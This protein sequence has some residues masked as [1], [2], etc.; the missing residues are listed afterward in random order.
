MKRLSNE[1]LGDLKD[2]VI[3]SSY[4]RDQLQPGIVHLGLGAF[5]RAHQAVFTERAIARGDLRWGIVGV[6]LRSPDTADALGPQDGL[7]TVCVRDSGK[8][9]QEVI[10]ALLRCLVAPQD[11]NAVLDSM[12]DPRCHIVSLTVTEKGY[13]RNPGNGDL[14][15]DDPA[16]IAD[17]KNIETPK[18]AIGF[19]VRA[20]ALRRQ[21]GVAPFTVLSCDN[22]PAN[23][24]ATQKVVLQFARILDAD[25]ARWI[26]SEV[27]FPNTMIDRIVPRTSDEDREQISADLGVDDAWPVVTEPFSQWVVEDRFCGPRPVWE[28]VGATLTGDVARYENAKL[29]MLNASHSAL[30]YMG[31]VAGLETVDQAI[32]EPEMRRLVLTMMAREVEPTLSAPRLS[33]YRSSLVTRFQNSSLK[34]TLRQI[35]MDGSQKIPQRWLMTIAA[36]ISMGVKVP[37]LTF[38][39]ASWIVYLRKSES[40]SS[41]PILDTLRS[42]VTGASVEHVVAQLLALDMF[43]AHAHLIH[44]R[45]LTDLKLYITQ[46]EALG[47]QRALQVSIPL[48]NE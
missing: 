32:A 46:I 38:A 23:G 31:L 22:L 21:A 25:L 10:R 24:E 35:A 4:S 9:S 13:L 29:R 14:L 3:T 27:S 20:L 26:A 42:A 36:C 19:I 33:A 37:C 16:V 39:L 2:G 18:T 15:V 40:P 11:T 47:I 45:L 8:Q 43:S 12:A 48:D 28:D 44:V 17:L 30:A 1:T 41:D 7:Y 6:S 34:H 5:H